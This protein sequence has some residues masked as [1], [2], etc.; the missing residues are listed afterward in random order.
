MTARFSSGWQRTAWLVAAASVCLAAG[1]GSGPGVSPARSQSGNPDDAFAS[2]HPRLLF[3]ATELPALRARV[4]DGGV[5]DAAYAFIRSRYTEHYLGAPFDSLLLNDFALEQVVNIGLCTYLEDAPDPAAIE[6]G[7]ALTLHIARNWEVDTDPFGTSLRLRAISLGFDMFFADATPAERQELREE[8]KR[9]INYMTT[10]LNYDIWRR[11]PYVSNKTAMVSGALGLAG[12]AFQDE[13]DASYTTAARNMA[14][15][16]FTAWRD[17]HLTDGAYRE[18]GLYIGWSL[19]NLIYYFAARERFDGFDYAQDPTLRAVESWMPYE[20]DPRGRARLNNIQDQTD[21]FLPLARHT[22]YWSWA[23]HEWGSGIAAYMW[24]RAVGVYGA[25]LGDESD[26]A[27]TVLWHTGVPPVNPGDL[28]PRSRVWPDRG[29]FYYR[30]GWPDG[31]SSGDVSFS[32]YSGAFQ[33]GHAQEDQN[34]FT[35]AVYG[36]KLILDHGAGSQAKQSEAHNIIRID[37]QGQHNAGSSIGTDGNLA[38]YITSSFADVVTGD[39][40][41]AYSTH[42]PYNNAGV[43]YAWSNWSWGLTGAN[44]VQKAVRRVLAVHEP[45]TSPYFVVEDDI[46]KDD[47][48]HRYDWCVHLPLDATIDAQAE[49]VTVDAGAARLGIHTL[50]PPRA[51]LVTSLAAFDNYSEDPNSRLLTVTANGVEPRFTM[52]LLP[53][54]IGGGE[55]GVVTTATA[56]GSRC[57]IAWNGVDADVVFVRGPMTPDGPVKLGESLTLAGHAASLETDAELGVVRARDGKLAGYVLAEATVLAR[58]AEPIVVLE[59]GPASLVYDGE[60]VHVDHENAQFRIRAEGVAGVRYRGDPV[61][62][63]MRD[64]FWTNVGVTAVGDTPAGGRLSVRAF[65]NPFN[66]SVRIS[67]ENPARGPVRGVLYDAAGRR[68]ATLVSGVLAA[69]AHAVEWD[70]REAGG[71]AAASG[72]YFLRVHAGGLQESIKLVLLR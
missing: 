35:L 48:A 19:R 6:L 66:P 56:W 58:G 31:A 46:R 12:I 9:Y 59:D 22:T 28:L 44:P 61:P 69:G 25:D 52:L 29:L 67:F 2:R 63:V 72:V 11:R 62:V 1:S 70:G 15:I 53:T 13:I 68:V 34:Q 27:A 10:N 16:M 65:P 57:E 14:D 30:S 47:A 55:P 20:L 3:Q 24:D 38:S 5:D 4:R 71:A 64:G 21:Y 41:L 33:G 7:R 50:H 37:G 39:A 60:F 45:G 26:H 36:E 18:G 17:S 8:A 49:P 51:S 32:F 54:R 40:T 42:S 43:P 23:Q